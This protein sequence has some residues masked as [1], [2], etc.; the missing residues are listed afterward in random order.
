MGWWEMVLQAQWIVPGGT[1]E[2]RNETRARAWRGS[3]F[4]MASPVSVTT[5]MRMY[6]YACVCVY[7]YVCVGEWGTPGGSRRTARARTYRQTCAA[8]FPAAPKSLRSP[9]RHTRGYLCRRLSPARL[10]RARPPFVSRAPLRSSQQQ[11]SPGRACLLRRCHL[12]TCAVR[13]PPCLRL[14]WRT[15]WRWS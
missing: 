15:R 9:T 11:G 12:V 14:R 7:V 6:K 10:A 4:P 8:E 1:E 2:R 13:P 5:C 3:T